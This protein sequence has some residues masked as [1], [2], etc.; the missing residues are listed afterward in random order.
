[1]TKRRRFPKTYSF[2]LTVTFDKG[3]RAAHALAQ[4]RNVIYGEFYTTSFNDAE[5]DTLR[6][7]SIK[8]AKPVRNRRGRP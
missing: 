1:M 7:R 5:P 8:S 3:C 4:V 6:V 2:V